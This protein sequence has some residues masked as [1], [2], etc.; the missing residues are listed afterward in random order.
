MLLLIIRKQNHTTAE[1][2]TQMFAHQTE[3]TTR[4]VEIL[5][6]C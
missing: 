4:H 3:N 6:R 1:K 2:D 5:K